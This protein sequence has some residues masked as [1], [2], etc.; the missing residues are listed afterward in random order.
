MLN[1][2]RLYNVQ[3]ASLVCVRLVYL[4]QIIFPTLLPEKKKKQTSLM[5]KVVQKYM[6]I[7]FLLSASISHY[8]EIK[9][10]QKETELLHS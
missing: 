8:N 6:F 10:K 1:V 9:L 5:L 7:L 3:H 2:H 4:N